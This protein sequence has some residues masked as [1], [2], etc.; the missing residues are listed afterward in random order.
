M[1]HLSHQTHLRRQLLVKTHPSQLDV[2]DTVQLDVEFRVR[3][4]P[5]GGQRLTL[6]FV[7]GEKVQLVLPDRTAEGPT[8]LLVRVGEH[9]EQH[10]IRSVELAVA[11]VPEKR[12]QE[13][14]GA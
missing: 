11:K 12:S 5:D 3:R 2:S 10:W 9:A 4:V 14:I 1:G 8:D 13:S 7:V 6:V